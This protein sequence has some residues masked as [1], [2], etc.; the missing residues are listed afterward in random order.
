MVNRLA[1]SLNPVAV[2]TALLSEEVIERRVWEEARREGVSHYD[3]NLSLLGEVMRCVE[4]RPAVFHQ[5]CSV[6]EQETVTEELAKELKGKL[7]FLPPTPP[8][9]THTL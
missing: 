3:R 4:A 9:P 6:L 5:F 7:E 2:A 8:P 1:H